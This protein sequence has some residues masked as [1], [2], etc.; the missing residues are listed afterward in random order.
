MET[1]HSEWA[2]HGL[3]ECLVSMFPSSSGRFR[4]FRLIPPQCCPV[5]TSHRAHVFSHPLSSRAPA[6]RISPCRPPALR[7]ADVLTA[8]SDHKARSSSQATGRPLARSTSALLPSPRAICGRIS[9]T[10]HVLARKRGDHQ[11]PR[12]LRSHQ[13]ARRRSR[14][15]SPTRCQL[16]PPISRIG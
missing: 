12:R 6:S 10:V 8:R 11:L 3:R 16:G 5:S 1:S 7:P 9:A 13:F 14:S 4:T 15:S 2:S